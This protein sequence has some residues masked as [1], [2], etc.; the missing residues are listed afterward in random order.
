MIHTKYIL[1]LYRQNTGFLKAE[2]NG[3]H[4]VNFS[5]FLGHLFSNP[6][7]ERNAYIFK[8][9]VFCIRRRTTVRTISVPTSSFMRMLCAASL[10]KT[11]V[12]VF[13]RTRSKCTRTHRGVDFLSGTDGSS[14]LATLHGHPEQQRSNTLRLTIHRRSPFDCEI[15]LSFPQLVNAESGF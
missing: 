9:V 6:S 13:G 1:T 8:F 3:L 12:S 11:G 15:F 4:R 2:A 7:L 10:T 14:I 5:P